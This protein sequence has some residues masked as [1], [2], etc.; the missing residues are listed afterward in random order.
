MGR[1]LCDWRGIR[2]WAA[3]SREQAVELLSSVAGSLRVGSAAGLDEEDVRVYEGIAEAESCNFLESGVGGLSVWVCW[4]LKCRDDVLGG[5]ELIAHPFAHCAQPDTC[6]G[7]V[8]ACRS[9]CCI[10]M[11]T[12]LAHCWL[13]HR[14]G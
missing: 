11:A 5:F 10:Q 13:R 1:V 14:A 9:R 4:M 3:V 8:C 6:T 7:A 12:S 2:E